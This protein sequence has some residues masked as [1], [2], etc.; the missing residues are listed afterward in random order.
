MQQQ[1]GHE[2]FPARTVCRVLAA[3]NDALALTYI[4]SKLVTIE[5]NLCLEGGGTTKCIAL[6]ATNTP[7]NAAL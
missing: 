5:S 4:T 6:A 2:G 1:N 7:G 3:A